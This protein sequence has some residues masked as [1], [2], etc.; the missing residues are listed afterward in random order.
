MRLQPQKHN[1]MEGKLIYVTSIMVWHFAD[2]MLLMLIYQ[3]IWAVKI[4]FYCKMPHN[5][6]KFIKTSP[7][8][9]VNDGH[10]NRAQC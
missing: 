5:D 3:H 1:S 10:A 4:C 2:C 9:M 7:S 6:L 8:T